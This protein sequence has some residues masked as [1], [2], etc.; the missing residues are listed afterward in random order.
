MTV[1]RTEKFP[2]R[3]L[4]AC[5]SFPL[6]SSTGKAGIWTA[7]ARSLR[8]LC[9]LHRS[10][11]RARDAT[12]SLTLNTMTSGP[13][14]TTLIPILERQPNVGCLLARIM[15]R[16]ARLSIIGGVVLPRTWMLQAV[17]RSPMR[18]TT[19]H[20]IKKTG[21][22]LRWRPCHAYRLYIMRCAST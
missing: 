5:C 11:G 3:R 2:V 10:F 6:L 4:M 14:A 17:R 12:R 9:H 15:G 8:R 22:R 13:A 1:F 19:D 7:S 20:A 21:R 16:A 18:A